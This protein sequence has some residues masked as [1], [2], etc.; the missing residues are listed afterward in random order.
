MEKD[1]QESA[2]LCK[3]LEKVR[4]P[5][6][7]DTSLPSEAVPCCRPLWQAWQRDLHVQPLRHP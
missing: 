7:K 1:I 2:E 3:K 4:H 5:D 6:A